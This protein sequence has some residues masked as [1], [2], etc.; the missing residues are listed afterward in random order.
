M[1]LKSVQNKLTVTVVLGSGSQCVV[2]AAIM[3]CFSN[4]LMQ[5]LEFTDNTRGLS[6]DRLFGFPW[7]PARTVATL[8]CPLQTDTSTHLQQRLLLSTEQA[9]LQHFV[10]VSQVWSAHRKTR[11]VPEGL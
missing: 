2:T 8:V 3:F 11:D 6:V 1:G 9:V 10:Q 7:Q 4:F 5:L